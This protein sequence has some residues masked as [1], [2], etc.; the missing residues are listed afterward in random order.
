MRAV[1]M[2][3]GVGLMSLLLVG[4]GPSEPTDPPVETPSSTPTS[5]PSTSPSPSSAVVSIPDTCE[6][7]IPLD[8]VHS[9]YGADF[10]AIP[11]TDGMGSGDAEG[12]RARGGL[13]CMW[14]LPASEYGITV[15]VAPRATATDAEQIALWQSAG[16]SLGPDFLDATYYELIID[17][18]G[19]HMTVWSLV[20]GFE[21]KAHSPIE[22]VDPLLV[23]LR[24][25]SENMGYV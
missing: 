15:F 14:G 20:E 16:Y 11:I 3:A 2:I 21:L 6:D 22:T 19:H 12:F 1:S 5:S 8:W 7:L 25:A 13:A 10:E 17:D 24:E 4:C 23:V 18:F 9:Q